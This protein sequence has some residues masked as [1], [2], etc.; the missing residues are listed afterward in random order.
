MTPNCQI[1]PVPAT[2]TCHNCRAF[3][4]DKCAKVGKTCPYC[5]LSAIV[6]ASEA[7]K[8]VNQCANHPGIRAEAACPDC[9]RI[10]CASCL[11]P[12]GQCLE[13]G[14][15]HPRQRPTAA[16]LEEP[17]GTGPGRKRMHR[18]P[19]RERGGRRTAPRRLHL[20]VGRFVIG[21]AIVA[22]IG[23]LLS[24]QYRSL[25][26]ALVGSK[27]IAGRLGTLGANVGAYK[28]QVEE[29]GKDL[30]EI[31]GRIESGQYSPEDAA[32][33]DD[34]LTRIESGQADLNTLAV[35]TRQKL[36]KARSLLETRAAYQARGEE[37]AGEDTGGKSA[38]PYQGP[39][40]RLRVGAGD[41]A[42]ARA[43]GADAVAHRISPRSK[44]LEISITSPV[45]GARLHGMAIVSARLVG[46]G[47][48]RVEFQVNGQWQGLSNQPPYRYEW[49][50]TGVR[51]GAVTLRV[52]AYDTSGRQVAS[53]PV[54]VT[55]QN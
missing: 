48:D 3:T 45:Q 20:G 8:A 46:Q 22:G 26:R 7:R 41:H 30:D 36:E 2:G 32:A 27:G 34:L 50:T 1:H 44:P 12:F 16:M 35:G 51:N 17:A 21:A 19:G 53:R 24:W 39:P 52:V 5:K 25:E 47:V 10:F 13:C 40:I 4:C 14:A 29:H 55:V 31:M 33:V 9:N 23:A 43:R 11:N 49:D 18:R 42:A 54:R 6:P 38:R 37:Y 15:R 28:R